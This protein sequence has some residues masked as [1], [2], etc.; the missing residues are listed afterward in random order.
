MILELNSGEFYICVCYKD[1]VSFYNENC[2]QS[3][4]NVIL[5][6]NS[7]DTI[8]TV[9]H[10]IYAKLDIKPNYQ[11]LE[12]KSVNQYT[13]EKCQSCSVKLCDTCTLEDYND[14]LFYHLLK[15][16]IYLL[17]VKDDHDLIK[18]FYLVQTCDD[19]DTSHHNPN[20]YLVSVEYNTIVKK[21]YSMV[22]DHYKICGE[23]VVLMVNDNQ[24][25]HCND[26][27]CCFILQLF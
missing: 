21:L 17:C 8:L 2:G 3:P 16:R 24:I 10:L 4:K 5:K 18:H 26:Y 14:L 6:V 19:L 12:Y 15:L 13:S 11:Y 22:A 25:V 20:D 23:N 7:F 9:K 27:M 1:R